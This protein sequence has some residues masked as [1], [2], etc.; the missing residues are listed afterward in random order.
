MLTFNIEPK[1]TRCVLTR[2]DDGELGVVT[3]SQNVI[4]VSKDRD[5][6]VLN[7]RAPGHKPMTRRIVSSATGTGMAS[8]LLIDFGITDLA[9]GAMWKYPDNQNISLERE[10]SIATVPVVVPAAA[11]AAPENPP[12]GESLGTPAATA[13]PTSAPVG[14]AK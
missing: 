14:T 10:D 1:E 6:I 11:A 9:T 12:S 13:V 7:C 8:V 2:V 5:D 3:A 4:T